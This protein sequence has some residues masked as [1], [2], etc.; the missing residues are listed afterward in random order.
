MPSVPGLP[1]FFINNL[2]EHLVL[3]TAAVP[4]LSNGELDTLALGQRDPRLLLAN[5][6]DVALPG[7]EG[8]VVGVLD[9]DNVETTIM[10]FPVGNDTDTAHVSAT[11]DH[12]EGTGVELGVFSDFTSSKVDLDSVVDLD[13]GVG[14][15]DTKQQREIC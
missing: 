5:D 3:S 6:E 2:R 8:V 10:A 11:S 14:V 12:S 15:S 1:S 13:Q 9:V 4:L 7:G